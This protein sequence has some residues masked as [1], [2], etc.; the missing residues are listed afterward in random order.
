M[1]PERFL[2]RQRDRRRDRGGGEGGSP[3]RFRRVAAAA[4]LFL[5]AAGLVLTRCFDAGTAAAPPR[6]HASPVTT[7]PP[8]DTTAL[9]RIVPYSEHCSDVPG[10][11]A[12]LR[13]WFDNVS[14]QYRLLGVT[15][16]A[17]AYR[18][19]AGAPVVVERTGP[20]AC[21][22]GKP[23]ERAW[24]QPNAPAQ[25]AGRYRCVIMSGR[26]EI[27]WTNQHRGLLGHAVALDSDL[28]AL[29]TWWR[30]RPEA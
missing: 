15:A 29:F 10:A 6:R 16:A 28:G 5:L 2:I 13:C 18:S 21:G 12:E 20:P 11:V 14:V 27:W 26:A 8:V 4:L 17:G 7:A 30:A 23:E 22:R 19:K 24:S 1:T 3:P 25:T 9:R